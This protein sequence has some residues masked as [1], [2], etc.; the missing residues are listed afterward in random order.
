MNYINKN[1]FIITILIF[2]FVFSSLTAIFD[3]A[4]ANISDS[5]IRL[6]VIANS[7]SLP[8]QNIK[9]MVRDRILKD[10]GDLFKTAESPSD[11]L[12]KAI[13]QKEKLLNSAKQ[14][15]SEQGLSPDI[16]IETGSF[17]FPAK[18]YGDIMLPAGRYNAVRVV[19]GEGKGKNWWCVLYPPLC[20]AK[21]TL[22][23]SQDSDAYLKTRLSENEYNLIKTN[24]H[25]QVEI[26][27]KLLEIFK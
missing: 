10:S 20:L 13:S 14:V 12:E 26:R 11:A 7:N 16:K 8:D 19:I 23:L 4:K 21:G 1:R 25:Q 27:F 2:S 5:V 17:P 24:P 18:N 15:L 6:H 9:L 22:T 3:T